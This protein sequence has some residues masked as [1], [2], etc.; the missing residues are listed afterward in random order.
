MAARVTELGVGL[1]GHI[2]A[3]TAVEG[4]SPGQVRTQ[5][6]LSTRLAAHTSS[7]MLQTSAN[8]ARLYSRRHRLS[9]KGDSVMIIQ[10]PQFDNFKQLYFNLV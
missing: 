10:V 9:V 8:D 3:Q 6:K 5:R 1:E 2:V 4:R 7:G